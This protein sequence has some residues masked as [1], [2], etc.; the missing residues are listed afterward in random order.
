MRRPARS[1]SSSSRSP[2]T[3]RFAG[4]VVR[5]AHGPSYSSPA[6]RWGRSPR[7][8]LRREQSAAEPA[9]RLEALFDP[10]MPGRAAAHAQ[11]VGVAAARRKDIARHE[12]DPL[13]QRRLEELAA[14][15]R[16][17]ELEPQHE[18]A[19]GP[20]DSGAPREGP[21][22]R[23]HHPIDVLPERTAN[24]AQMAVVPTARQAL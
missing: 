4:Y 15:Q 14:R 11:T 18:A 20:T 16:L 22:D 21:V 23:A 3:H 7:A 1:S 12:A 9:E 6:R 8:C 10:G 13:L 2:S 5:R 19:I 24:A 17:G